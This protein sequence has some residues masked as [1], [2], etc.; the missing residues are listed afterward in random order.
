MSD[1]AR[2]A[3]GVR[4]L[5]ASAWAFRWQVEREAE[6]R[7]E[8]LAARLEALDEPSHLVALARRASADERRHAEHCA[9]L[10]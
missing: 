6:V 9:W 4:A 1:G 8:T 10:A 7:F 2:P 5:A 3:S